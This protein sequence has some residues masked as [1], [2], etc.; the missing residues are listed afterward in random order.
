MVVFCDV[1]VDGCVFVGGFEL[2]YVD[3]VF[4]VNVCFVEFVG[5][6]FSDFGLNVVSWYECIVVVGDG[7]CEDFMVEVVI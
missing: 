7:E 5:W 1:L 4:F 3:F 2:G 6:F